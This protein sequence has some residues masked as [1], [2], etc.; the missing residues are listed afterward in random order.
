VTP[1]YVPELER[2]QN[3]RS[4][5]AE[6]RSKTATNTDRFLPDQDLV[7]WRYLTA[8]AMPEFGGRVFPG[9]ELSAY[10]INEDEHRTLSR[11]TNPAGGFLV[12]SGF[13]DQITAARRARNVISEL[14]RQIETDHGRGI[15][16]PTTTAHGT[17][18]WTAEN[19]AV[20][21]TDET[22]GQV[23]LNAFKASAKVIVSEE[24]RDDA[25]FSLDQYLGQELGQRAALL[26]ETAFAVGD[27]TG[28]PLG[29]VTSGNGVATVTAATGSA[30][31]FTLADVRSVWAALPEAYKVNASWIM[32]PSA[33]ASLANLTG[34]GVLVLPSLHA[35][36]PTLYT[37]PVFI[38]PE[39][40]AAGASARS[41]VVGDIQLGYAVRR[42]RG[43]G[44]KRQD[45]I[46]SDNGQVGYV[47]FERVD[48]R[49]VLA[50]A[51]RILVH[52][53]T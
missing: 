17:A 13:D 44:V 21:A 26:E 35:A 9:D 30:S 18:S 41:V 39:L 34:G 15:P 53:A 36:E 2:R 45:E 11:A 4:S 14:A 51:L 38:S 48:G 20:S 3:G 50:D 31:G 22:F 8:P 49:V 29:I 7:F 6:F 46:H 52:S 12:P 28:K 33:F 37:R 10:V 40:P 19:A 1:R 25:E 16:L 47:L 27:G 24:L 5:Y 23:T 32:S 43:L 42:A